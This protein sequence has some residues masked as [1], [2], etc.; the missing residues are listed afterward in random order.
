M[1][2]ILIILALYHFTNLKEPSGISVEKL[3][4]YGR[5]KDHKEF[6]APQ[7][8]LAHPPLPLP[9]RPSP[10]DISITPPKPAINDVPAPAPVEEPFDISITPPKPATNDVPAPA[11]VSDFAPVEKPEEPIAVKPKES[12]ARTSSVPSAPSS[13]ELPKASAPKPAD[14]GSLLKTDKDGVPEITLGSDRWHQKPVHY[15]VPK[16]SII[17][18]PT[19]NPKK[20]PQIQAK[21]EPET[22]I[23]KQE[24]LRRQKSV[25]TALLKDWKAYKQEAWGRDEVSPITGSGRDTF[26][27]WGATLVDALDTLWIMGLEDEFELALKQVAKID[28]TTTT[29][30]KI[31]VFETTIRYLG[32]LLGAYDLS[33]GKYQI[34][35]DKAIEIGDVL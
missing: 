35:L 8:P 24:R 11:P 13:A 33:D 22:N 23:D 34:L 9:P 26:G 3:K 20:L 10:F 14:E 19:G 25:K 30:A 15:P 1:L 16:E 21:F 4:E 7:E 6:S 28:F 2:S 29:L 31:P 32:G 17:P 12:V 5:L 18:L 27:G